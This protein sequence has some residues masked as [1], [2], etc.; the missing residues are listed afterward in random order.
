MPGGYLRFDLY[1]S[2]CKSPNSTKRRRMTHEEMSEF[3]LY[4]VGL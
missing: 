4:E 2:Y 1:R 3:E